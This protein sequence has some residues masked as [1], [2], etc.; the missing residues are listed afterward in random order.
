M[1]TNDR[2]VAKQL[3][4]YLTDHML[5]SSDEFRAA[6]KHFNVTTTCLHDRG[7]F[8]ST[9][10]RQRFLVDV[11]S[12]ATIDKNPYGVRYEFDHWEQAKAFSARERAYG[13]DESFLVTAS[14]AIEA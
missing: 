7:E 13:E 1:Q 14:T 8:F 3:L 9:T 11:F 4:Q 6:L 5:Y 10:F 12:P 2:A